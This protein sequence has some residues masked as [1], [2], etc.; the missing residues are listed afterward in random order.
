M[1]SSDSLPRRGLPLVD[2]LA[3]YVE[4]DGECIVWTGAKQN[5]YG[6]L[7]PPEGRSQRAHRLVWEEFVEPIPDGLVLDHLCGNKACVNPD[8]LEPVTQGQNVL[9]GKSFAAVNARKTHCL[10][11]HPFDDVNT[12]EWNGGRI[13]R[14]CRRAP[15]A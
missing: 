4:V 3:R 12:Y 5:G 6:T 8:H 9:R 11:G 1:L 7:H 10:R 14:A 15:D 2:R 13:C